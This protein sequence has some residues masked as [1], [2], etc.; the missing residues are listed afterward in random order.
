MA[1]LY[2]IF[3]RC[4]LYQKLF[5]LHS[6]KVV[7]EKFQLKDLSEIDNPVDILKEKTENLRQFQIEHELNA[8]ATK[9]I[10]KCSSSKRIRSCIDIY[11]YLLT[12]TEPDAITQTALMSAYIR[13]DHNY[14]TTY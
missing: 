4:F 7:F 5:P 14:I 6:N 10:S 8:V 13:Y 3:V 1:S 11:N 12:V 2:H 9:L